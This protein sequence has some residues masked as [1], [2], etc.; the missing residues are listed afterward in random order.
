MEVPE[1]SG[2]EVRGFSRAFFGDRNRIVLKKVER[3][4]ETLTKARI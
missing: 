3:S 4:V 2:A 1:R